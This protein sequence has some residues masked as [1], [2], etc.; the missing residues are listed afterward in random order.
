MEH[1]Y[2]SLNS[3]CLARYLRMLPSQRSEALHNICETGAWA[4]GRGWETFLQE[5]KAGTL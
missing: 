3:Q 2:L 1:Q 4:G 5:N